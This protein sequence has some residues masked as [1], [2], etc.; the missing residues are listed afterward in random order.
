[1]LYLQLRLAGGS[2]SARAD[3]YLGGVYLRTGDGFTWATV[4][5][6]VTFTV[7]STSRMQVTPAHGSR[8]RLGSPLGAT[9]RPE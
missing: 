3:D 9:Q 8:C 5:V 1:M 2:S 4:T 6:A 7:S